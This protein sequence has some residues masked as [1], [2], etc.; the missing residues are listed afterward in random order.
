[1]EIR[2]DLK[3]QSSCRSVD[4]TTLYQEKDLISCKSKIFFFFPRYDGKLKLFPTLDLLRSESPHT[5]QAKLPGS[6]F[7]VR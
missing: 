3:S 2:D 4:V 5:G 7:S 1:M 6:W